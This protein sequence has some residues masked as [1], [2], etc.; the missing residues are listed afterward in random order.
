MI[1]LEYEWKENKTADFKNGRKT[2]SLK[3]DELCKLCEKFFGKPR[4]SSSSHRVYKTPWVVN[5]RINIQNKK[6]KA[7]FYQVQQV[8]KAIKKLEDKNG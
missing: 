2:N 5:P 1:L 8:L 6:G 4:Q 7:K 3:Y